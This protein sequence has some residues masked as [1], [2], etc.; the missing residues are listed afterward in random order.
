MRYVAAIATYLPCWGSARGRV[1]G[2]DEDAVTLAVEAGRA[3]IGAAAGG[4][5]ADE[6]VA[7]LGSDGQGGVRRVVLV[8]RELPLLEGG[9]AAVLLAGLGLDPGTEVTE[10][11]GGAPAALDA[12][13]SAPPWTLVIAA[14][15]Q[16]AAGGATP[17]K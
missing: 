11:L 5:A 14:D 10:R 9:N 4:G 8:S 6:G 2:G 16:P 3:A 17:S 13:T 1:A 12:L 15:V 7:D